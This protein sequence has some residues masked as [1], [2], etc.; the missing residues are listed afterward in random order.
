MHI[1]DIEIRL[2]SQADAPEHLF[3]ARAPY[4]DDHC[5]TVVAAACDKRFFE[6]ILVC[7]ETL[8]A[9]NNELCLRTDGH[10]K[11]RG[12]ENE[13]VHLEYLFQ[14]KLIIILNLKQNII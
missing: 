10:K 9:I 12:C 6:H 11:N 1:Q 2:H 14:H 13:A 4:G 8:T 3:A 5:P 7:P